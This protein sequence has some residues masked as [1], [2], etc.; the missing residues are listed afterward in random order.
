MPPLQSVCRIVAFLFYQ[1]SIF[2]FQRFV[3]YMKLPYNLK[4][5]KTVFLMN[6]WWVL[7]HSNAPIDDGALENVLDILMMVHAANLTFY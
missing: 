7:D 3:D 6:L 4:V 1:H 2:L 5:Y